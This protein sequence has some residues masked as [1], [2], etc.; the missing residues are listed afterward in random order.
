MKVFITGGTGFLGSHLARTLSGKGV[1]C[2]FIGRNEK[3]G[4]EYETPLAK[5]EKCDTSDEARVRELMRGHTHV[6][7]SAALTSHWGRP[8]DFKKANLDGTVSLLKA[9]KENRIERFIQISTPSVYATSHPRSMIRESDPLPRFFLND[10]ARTKYLA[11]LKVLEA[12]KEGL[13]TVRLRPQGIF[14]PGDQAVFPK[15]IDVARRGFIP[16]VGDGSNRIDLTYVGNVV[17]GILSTLE[18]G[19]HIR[20]KVYNLT[21]DEPI[22]NYEVIKTVLTRLNIP[23]KEKR[24]PFT[25]SYGLGATLEFISRNFQNYK[26]PILTRYTAA[27]L[28]LTRTLCIDEA[29]KDLAYKPKVSMAEGID[30]FIVWW[31]AK[32]DGK[33]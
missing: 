29:K 7:H 19:S 2:T 10:Y 22:S 11:E 3:L 13:F 32:E 23:Y 12:E 27:T 17:D 15:I 30:R 18:S 31:K 21:N 8:E 4:R 14:G 25:L 28:A 26:E 5:F 9:A 16:V 6:V 24:L 33:K 1:S 20:G